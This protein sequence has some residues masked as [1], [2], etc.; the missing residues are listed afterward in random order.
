MSV[1]YNLIGKRIQTRRKKI[2][3]TQENLAEHLSVSVGY[4]SQIERGVTKISLDTLSKISTF[5]NCDVTEFISNAT[6]EQNSYLDEEFTVKYKRLTINQKKML[7]EIM[8]AILK[9]S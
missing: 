5:L 7:I 6:I 4:I 9:N 2:S 1:D 3:K 8:E